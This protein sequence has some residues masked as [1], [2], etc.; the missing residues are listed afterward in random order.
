MPSVK[1][2]LTELL[3]WVRCIALMVLLVTHS[4]ACAVSLSCCNNTIAVKGCP[5]ADISIMSWT[6]PF[7]CA[8]MSRW[9]RG[10]R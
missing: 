8:M 2:S 4:L 6:R 3:P 10:G 5:Q 1:K 9:F 7:L